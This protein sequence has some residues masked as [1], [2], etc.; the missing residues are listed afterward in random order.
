MRGIMYLSSIAAALLGFFLV[1]L[2]FVIGPIGLLGLFGF[3]LSPILSL[4]GY[5]GCRKI[6]NTCSS[7]K[8]DF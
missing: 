2:T 3:I 8:R 7:C 4:N 6:V 5:Y 1:M